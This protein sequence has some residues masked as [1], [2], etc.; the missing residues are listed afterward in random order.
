MENGTVEN[1]PGNVSIDERN[2]GASATGD[3]VQARF[4]SGDQQEQ[5]PLK[6]KRGRPKGSKNRN[7]AGNSDPVAGAAEPPEHRKRAAATGSSR[8]TKAAP[9]LAVETL[10][11]QIFGAHKIIATLAKEPI[12]E[13]TEAESKSLA[14]AVIGVIEQYEMVF[15][16]RVVAWVQLFGVA[17]AVYGPR[18]VIS[19]AKKNAAKKQNPTE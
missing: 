19:R 16:P 18:V 17:A 12:Y 14:R 4:D 1:N 9:S 2:S 15:D 11:P 7:A 6:R 13:V 10:A 5:E 8:P 3:A